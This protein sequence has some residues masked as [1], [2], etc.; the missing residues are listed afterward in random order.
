MTLPTI[1]SYYSPRPAEYGARATAY[2]EPVAILEA[3]CAR[4]GLRH[5]LLTEQGNADLVPSCVARD[6]VYEIGGTQDLKLMQAIIAG[7]LAYLKAEGTGD[8]TI[9]VGVDCLFLKD[10][11]PVFDGGDWD[12]AVTVGPYSPGALNNGAVFLA[13]NRG[14]AAAT[15]YTLALANCPEEWPGDQT[16][17]LRVCSPLRRPGA[18]EDRHGVK[19]RYLSMDDWNLPPASLDDPGIPR[20]TMLHFKGARKEFMAATAEQW[21]GIPR[22][23]PEFVVRGAE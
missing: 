22:P 13:P 6:R 10:P 11:A 21:L 4:L 14:D 9:M 17:I 19:V 16:A 20:A 3:S 15:F 5:V 1:V 7:Q 8:G 18:V 23:V 12:V 2:D